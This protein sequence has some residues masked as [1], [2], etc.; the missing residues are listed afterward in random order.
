M[1]SWKQASRIWQSNDVTNSS[2]DLTKVSYTKVCL[3]QV[4]DC[5]S[6]GVPGQD[7]DPVVH[8]IRVHTQSKLSNTDINVIII[9]VSSTIM[10]EFSLL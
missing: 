6:T 3:T 7:R 9:H 4:D 8:V 5:V 2:A 10:N 1:D